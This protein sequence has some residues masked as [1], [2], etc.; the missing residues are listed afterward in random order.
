[1]LWPGCTEDASGT[2]AC[3][4]GERQVAACGIAL[5]G[6]SEV[7]RRSERALLRQNVSGKGITNPELFLWPLAG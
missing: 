5:R 2:G 7:E 6:S 3:S 4:H 1:M